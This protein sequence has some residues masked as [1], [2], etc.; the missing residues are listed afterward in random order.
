M[1]WRRGF[2]PPKS[3]KADAAIPRRLYE[4]SEARRNYLA[5]L[6]S[7]L[8]MVWKEDQLIE[9]IDQLQDMIAS[10]RVQKCFWTQRHTESFKKFI[11]RRRI[12]I[13]D[14]IEGGKSPDWTLEPR[15]MTGEIVKIGDSDSVFSLEWKMT[16]KTE[17]ALLPSWERGRSK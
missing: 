14:E 6:R 17:L 8:D 12:E 2:E 13:L 15:E 5:A 16:N 10:H 11:S 9:Q 1:F 3:V 7:L 4:N